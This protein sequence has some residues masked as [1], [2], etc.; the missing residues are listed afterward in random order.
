[1]TR[2]NHDPRLEGQV[3]R[4]W[5][6]RYPDYG[7]MT[8]TDLIIAYSDTTEWAMIRVRLAAGNLLRRIKNCCKGFTQ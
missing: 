2:R 3:A 8:T 1:M 7:F 5:L 4:E 6:K